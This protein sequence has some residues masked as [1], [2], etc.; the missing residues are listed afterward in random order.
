[1]N[2]HEAI[3][4][5]ESGKKVSH[6]Y[7]SDDEWMT[8][9]HNDNQILFEDG[10]RCSQEEFWSIR[11]E[12]GWEDGYTIVN[13][14]DAADKIL[15]FELRSLPKVDMPMYEDP[16]PGYVHRKTNLTNKQIKSRKRNN[17][18]R[19]AKKRNKVR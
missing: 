17:L 7:F 14:L 5:M 1:M 3:K 8:I 9:D 15:T 2:K 19:K 6:E 4:A 11:Q 12:K 16:H 13:I 10:C 18:A